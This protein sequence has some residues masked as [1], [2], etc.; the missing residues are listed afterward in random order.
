MGLYVLARP[1]PYINA[2][3]DSGGFPGWLSTQRGQ[4]RTHADD[5]QAAWEEWFD[6]VNPIIARHQ[7][8]DGGGS[9][10]L[11]QIENEYDRGDAFYMQE[12]AAAARADG[13]KVPI[14]HNDKK[15]DLL[16]STGPGA[17]ELYATDTYPAAFDC[18]RTT[19]PAVTDYRFLRA[20]VGQRPFFW[21]EFQG[22]AF[23]P[24]GGPGYERC[25]ALTGPVFERMFYANNI[26]NQFTVQNLYMVY[27]G[28]SWGWQADPNVVYTS[29]D[30]G[31]AFNEQRELTEKVPVLKQQ[32]Y[33]VASVRD[34]A[35]TDDLGLQPRANPAIR[36]W[37][38]ENPRTRAR[39]YFVRHADSTSPYDDIDA[40]R[41]R[42]TRR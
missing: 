40:A 14:F 5:Y 13:I 21:G 6:H 23:D 9:V 15:R 30:Y 26:E 2:E 20:G 8:V 28:T 38:K 3:L 29:Y 4:A 35:E 17:P 27:G 41:D 31:A 42:R 34:L 22:G 1:G 36:V 11:F 39:F 7:I 33:L 18:N 10:V 24:W 25:R 37:V 16:W 32:A 19:F 12:L